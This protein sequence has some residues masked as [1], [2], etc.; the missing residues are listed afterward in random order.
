MSR[1][2]LCPDPTTWRIT[3]IAPEG[4]RL[5]VHLEPMRTTAACPVCATPSMSSRCHRR[6]LRNG[7]PPVATRH[8]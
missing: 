7:I 4:D 5:V 3:R 2:P 6:S 1:E 8:D